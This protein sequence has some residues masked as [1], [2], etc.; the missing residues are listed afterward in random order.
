MHFLGAGAMSDL[1]CHNFDHFHLRAIYPGHPVLINLNVR[2]SNGGHRFYLF[3]NRNSLLARLRRRTRV[4]PRPAEFGDPDSRVDV[5]EEDEAVV[6]LR[7]PGEGGVGAVAFWTS[8]PEVRDLAP[9]AVE[10]AAQL[11]RH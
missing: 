10:V 7:A 8:R 9:L 11:A 4:G 6:R 2:F 1:I 5:V 3:T